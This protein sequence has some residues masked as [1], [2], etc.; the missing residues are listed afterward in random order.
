MVMESDQWVCSGRDELALAQFMRQLFAAEHHDFV[1]PLGPL[2]ACVDDPAVDADDIRQMLAGELW[3]ACELSSA[4]EWQQES[5]LQQWRKLGSSSKADRYDLRGH[6]GQPSLEEKFERFF[7]PRNLRIN[8]RALETA[9][10][11]VAKLWPIWRPRMKALSLETAVAIT[12]DDT[13]YGFPRCDS[14][15]ANVYY[16]YLEADR[17]IQ[18]GYPLADAMDYPC[19][20]TSRTQS[21]GYHKTPKRRALSMYCKSLVYLENMVRKEAFDSLRNLPEFVA[22]NGQ[23]A[24]DAFVTRLLDRE[25]GLILSADFTDFDVSVPPQVTT[26]V[27]KILAS[28]FGA[29]DQNLVRFIGEAFMRTGIYLPV[30]ARNPS[31]YFHG[32]QRT[33]GVP[34]GSAN[35]NL[36][37]CLANLIVMHYGAIV[38]GGTVEQITVN[39]DDAVVVFKGT[40]A[41]DVSQALEAQLGMIIK[42]DPSKNLVSDCHVKYLQMDHHKAGRNPANG[43]IEGWRPVERVLIKMTGHER[44]RPVKRLGL[45]TESPVKWSGFFNTF[46]WIQQMEPCSNSPLFGSQVCWFMGHDRCVEEAVIAISDGDPIVDLAC[47]MLAHEDGDDKVSVEAFR[48]SKVVARICQEYGVSF[49]G[50]VQ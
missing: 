7:T 35:T 27:F 40:T 43:L 2:R 20:G 4:P 34:S 8:L 49:P 50:A 21:A 10:E 9:A 23:V 24:V 38:T 39:G 6:D 19:V 13:N 12:K 16:Y 14:D 1:A 29:E 26:W 48:K 32:D 31:G 37:D 33:G 17:I 41:N 3:E 28:W 25:P 36:V 11:K 30:T 46:R 18:R 22:W 45:R 5:E 15:P 42:M 44:R 47:A